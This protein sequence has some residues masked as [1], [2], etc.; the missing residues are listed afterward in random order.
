MTIINKNHEEEEV[1]MEEQER[2]GEKSWEGEE[3]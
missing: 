1:E 2:A 3:E